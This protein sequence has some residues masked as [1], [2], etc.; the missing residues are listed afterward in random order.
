MKSQ[1]TRKAGGECS[2]AFSPDTGRIAVS[3]AA[4]PR[5]LH[6]ATSAISAIHSFGVSAR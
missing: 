4:Q 2:R 6:Y 5:A 3:S 1:V